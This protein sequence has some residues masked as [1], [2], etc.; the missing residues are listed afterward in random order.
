MSSQ[1]RKNKRVLTCLLL[2]LTML[3]SMHAIAQV[4]QMVQVKTFDQQLKPYKNL[5]LTLNDKIKVSMDAK[6]AA[7]IEMNESDLPIRAI[8]IKTEG[9]ETASWNF[10]KGTL[11]IIV[12]RQN[13]KL[14][15]VTIIDQQ[16]Q[17][18]V[19]TDVVFNGARRIPLRTN[20]EGNI[21]VP[22]GLEERINSSDQFSITGYQSSRLTA[23]N[24]AYFLSAERIR[25]PAEETKPQPRQQAKVTTPLVVAPT[26][27]RK[28]YDQEIANLDTVQ[29]LSSFYQVVR[30]IA[31]NELSRTQKN[32]VDAKFNDLMRKI[33][34]SIV[35]PPAPRVITRVS[36]AAPEEV[37]QL[38]E[39]VAQERKQME[40]QRTEDELTR[41]KEAQAHEQ[42]LIL[43]AG[44]SFIV[45]ATLLIMLLVAKRNV[46][47]HEEA[48]VLANS[49]IAQFYDDFEGRVADKTTSL[50][51]TIAELEALLLG[52]SHDLQT[53]I[54][55]IY[56]ASQSASQITTRELVGKVMGSAVVIDNLV[57]N[58]ALISE[59][60]Q[61]RHLTEISVC[62]VLQ[63]VKKKF[64]QQMAEDHVQNTWTCDDIQFKTNPA[65]FEAMITKLVENALFF[66]QLREKQAGQPTVIKV[67]ITNANKEI[68]LVVED[69]GI[70]ISE[71]FRPRIFDMF[72]K[73]S[74][75]SKG[76]GL[77]LFIVG[78]SVWH[79]Q[80]SIKIDTKVDSYTRFTIRLPERG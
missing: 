34:A 23:D 26:P 70:G 69:N 14:V 50:Q 61:P 80:G 27:V 15:T 37:R 4:K 64:E 21:Y 54:A 67:S 68:I 76:S 2:M 43:I 72:F 46:R 79:M 24:G 16:R 8:D 9:L 30:N 57:K 25:T 33:Q 40:I 48:L 7:F 41:N 17:P 5:E 35:Q 32:K 56:G 78:R 42:Q 52:A 66:G 36:V 47:K 44:T 75:K 58:M 74:E 18:I 10:S 73:G 55:S 60:N 3:V 31:M 6:G 22:L 59:L 19:R 12:R 51:K 63:K 45:A 39:K 49:Q 38:L 1:F 11:E 20:A 28:S 53:P 71:N 62:K 13:Y 65:F 77:G 29:S